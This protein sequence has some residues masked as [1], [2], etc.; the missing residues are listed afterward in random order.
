MCFKITITKLFCWVKT[1]SGC[2][3]LLGSSGAKEKHGVRVLL[4]R[5]AAPWYIPLF[6]FTLFYLFF[7]L[8]LF[9]FYLFQPR[10]AFL[11]HNVVPLRSNFKSKQPGGNAIT[12]HHDAST[13]F[14]FKLLYVLACLLFIPVT[15]FLLPSFFFGPFLVLFFIYVALSLSAASTCCCFSSSLTAVSV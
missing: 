11:L 4:Y 12:R 9:F 5:K 6:P 14:Y 1:L 8:I 7:A 15:F 3:I 10:H 2:L 13:I